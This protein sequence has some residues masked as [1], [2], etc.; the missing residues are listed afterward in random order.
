LIILVV[1]LGLRVAWMTNRSVIIE[2]EGGEYAAIAG[3]I[4]SGRGYVGQGEITGKPQIFFPP[5]YPM[6]IAA[7]ALTTRDT[8][9]AGRI[10]SLAMGLLLILALY[11][12]GNHTYGRRAGLIVAALA[13]THP[14]LVSLSILVQ[15]EATYI[16]L[17]FSGT[18]LAIRAIE[19]RR[20][21]DFLLCGALYGLAYLTRPEA[22]L[23]PGIVA[24]LSPIV[25]GVDRAG[26]RRVVQGIAGMFA[27]FLLMAAPYVTY[28]Y[29]QTGHIRLENK[30]AI[31]LVI[32]E[33]ILQGKN[34]TE[35]HFG[36]D[37]D[38]NEFGAH[39]GDVDGRI[40]NTANRSTLL[41]SL[42]DADKAAVR[43][44]RNL[45][46]AAKSNYFGGPLLVSLALAGFCLGAWSRRRAY[47]QAFLGLMVVGITVS[48]FSVE[49]FWPRYS[50]I[51][52]PFLLVCGAHAI[53]KISAWVHRALTTPW[54]PARAT[55]ASCAVGASMAAGVLLVA[56]RANLAEAYDD[57]GTNRTGAVFT[58]QA[59][60]WLRDQTPR[61]KVIMDA[62]SAIPYYSGSEYVALPYSSSQVA[63][64]Y[65][66]A[67]APDYVVLR[68]ALA[69]QRPYLDQWAEYG[70]PGNH[71]RLVYD[72]GVSK[73]ERIQ[74]YRWEER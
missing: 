16:A 64:R 45:A 25:A 30:S 60:L 5:L 58:K 12:L 59:G 71:G 2:N 46:G 17:T 61:E 39:M 67:K 1:A 51:L 48:L 68:G 66:D 37:D 38:L 21:R 29:T 49:F 47:V 36:V 31:Q 3:N 56:A 20:L 72:V 50:Y 44:A 42:Q 55:F 70:I 32:N 34:W 19:S 33:N 24:V 15:T 63:L 62:G 8:E 13:A 23:L 73:E 74:I 26:F 14:L 35:A 41:G 54:Q 11:K 10:V 28:L 53:D 52:L 65:I 6:A 69:N 40:I 57:F 27:V 18:Y 22:L 7:L 4:L 9:I 43:Q